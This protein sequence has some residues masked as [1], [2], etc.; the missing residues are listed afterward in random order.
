MDFVD[1]VLARENNSVP[2]VNKV[3]AKFDALPSPEVSSA[4]V[5]NIQRGQGH[6]KRII[7][8]LNERGALGEHHNA[9]KNWNIVFNNKSVRSVI[10]HG[11]ADGKLALLE[12]VPDLI[13]NGIYITT[14]I[15]NNNGGYRKATP[16]EIYT[17]NIL[18]SH[19]L[20][21]KASIDGKESIVGIV[22]K[23]DE[24]GKRYYDHAIKIGEQ[25]SSKVTNRRA[26][27]AFPDPQSTIIN[28]V[29]KHLA[30]NN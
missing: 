15:K 9:D 7:D 17:Q 26:P 16:K 29:Q 11:A 18:K 25:E 22:I 19:I 13:K 20:A 28:I 3:R 14:T 24:N 27:E 30:V 12:Y 1:D 21:A 6:P 23:E 8:W 2:I 10:S 5:R 4:D